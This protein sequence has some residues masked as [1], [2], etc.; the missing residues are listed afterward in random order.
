MLILGFVLQKTHILN[1]QVNRA[2]STMVVSAVYPMM[3]LYS[4]LGQSGDRRE[5]L[6]LLAGGAAIY[7]GMLLFGKAVSRVLRV[8]KEKRK[9][10][11]CL[12]VFGNT[13]FIGAPLAQSL[14][15]NAAFY[16]LTLMN[17]AY[18]VFY[19][20]YA[21]RTLSP[22]GEKQ[23]FRWKPLFTPGFVLTLL[24]IVL[25]LLQFDAPEMIRSTLQ[26]VGSM[27]TPLSMIILGAS[28]ASYPFRQSITDVWAYVYS[29]VKLMAMPAIAFFVCYLL[30]IDWYYLCLVILTTA[31]PAGSMVLMLAL[32][33]RR[34]SEFISKTIFVSTLLS[35]LSLPVVA[36]LFLK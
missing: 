19:N 8:P 15:G 20:T 9:E 31:M 21:V 7:C 11:E 27:T 35:A 10:F 34:N 28:L 26:M 4:M 17:F 32:Q 25:F 16:Q 30:R 33:M 13:G 36:F 12:M 22:E 5:A 14:L 23:G 24:A 18:Y 3:L 1:E 2:L 6:W 29:A